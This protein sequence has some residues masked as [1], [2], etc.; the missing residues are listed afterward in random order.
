MIAIFRCV[1]EWLMSE[2][3]GV[4]DEK[5]WL[6][7]SEL[8]KYLCIPDATLRR[9]IRQHG[10]RL[11]VKRRH[12]SYE[13]AKESVETLV[14]IREEYG[15]GKNVEA[16]EDM[17]LSIAAPMI[18]TVNDA[19]ERITVNL[20]EALSSL[21]EAVAEQMTIIQGLTQIIQEQKEEMKTCHHSESR[22]EQMNRHLTQWR[23]ERQLEQE[24]LES[25]V[26][27]PSKERMERV[28]W[29]R[30]EDMEARSRYIK[31]YICEHL[32]SRIMEAYG[33]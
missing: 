9:Y 30:K 16:V 25:W 33:M 24:A 10:H 3:N 1:T 4:T 26:K 29:I 32:E 27:K 2:V 7:V 19:D 21:Q 11:K 5:D 6:T 12:K 13:I 28:G 31:N 18:V 8:S 22:A 15:K 17:L 23:I 20:A 14:Q